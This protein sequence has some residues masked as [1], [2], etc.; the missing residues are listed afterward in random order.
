MNLNGMSAPAAG[1]G[2]PAAE[3]VTDDWVAAG[4][5]LDSD[6]DAAAAIAAAADATSSTTTSVAPTRHPNKRSMPAPDVPRQS[7]AVPYHGR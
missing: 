1:N 4:A 5:G 7:R 3:G 2:V 6:A